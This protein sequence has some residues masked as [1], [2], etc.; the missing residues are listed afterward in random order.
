MK[1]IVATCTALF[2]CLTLIA[3]DKPVAT[4]KV[5]GTV[6]DANGKPAADCIVS[7]AQNAKKMRDPYRATTDAEGKFTIEKVEPGDYNLNVRSADGKYK[8]IKSISV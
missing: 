8:A 4:G 3:A 2:L 7:L 5:V 6:E 1:P